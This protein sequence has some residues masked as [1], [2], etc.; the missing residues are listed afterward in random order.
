MTAVSTFTTVKGKAVGVKSIC[1]KE[2]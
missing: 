1:T 2:S